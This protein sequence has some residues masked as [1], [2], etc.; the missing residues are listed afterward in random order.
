MQ[1][2]TELLASTLALGLG[3]PAASTEV[4]LTG[5]QNTQLRIECN[6]ETCLVRERRLDGPWRVV[7]TTGCGA[8]SFNMLEFKYRAAGY[9]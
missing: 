1:L 4:L 5:P 9:T 3:G 6:V 8:H 2:M 7:E